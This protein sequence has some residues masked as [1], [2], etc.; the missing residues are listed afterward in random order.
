MNIRLLRNT[1]ALPDDKSQSETNISLLTEPNY[2]D[3]RYRTGTKELQTDNNNCHR[4][5]S[6]LYR[7]GSVYII[8]SELCVM[9]S[10]IH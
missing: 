3:N 1:A 5:I 6:Q 7:K 8:I 9:E 4:E 10:G 2:I